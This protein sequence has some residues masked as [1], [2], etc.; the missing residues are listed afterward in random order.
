MSGPW[1]GWV[2]LPGEIGEQCDVGGRP[3]GQKW[4]EKD[5]LVAREQLVA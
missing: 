3:I 2:V 1:C 4:F 5:A